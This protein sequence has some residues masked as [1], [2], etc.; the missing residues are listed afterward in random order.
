MLAPTGMTMRGHGSINKP[1][2]CLLARYPRHLAAHEDEAT[3]FAARWL[4]DSLD[5]PLE[6]RQG[7]CSILSVTP[8]D[9]GVVELSGQVKLGTSLRLQI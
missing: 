2:A 3:G 5:R 4:A 7:L 1:D 8:Q 6:I 9:A